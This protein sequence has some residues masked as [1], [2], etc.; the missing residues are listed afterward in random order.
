[1]R[2]WVESCAWLRNQILKPPK[3]FLTLQTIPGIRGDPVFS[4]ACWNF[5]QLHLMTFLMVLRAGRDVRSHLCLLLQMASYLP[6][7]GFGWWSGDSDQ[8]QAMAW[9][10]LH[11][12]LNWC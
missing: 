8:P 6:S 4:F 1:M 7:H 11:R 2:R 3:N 12:A 10:P 9:C 5:W